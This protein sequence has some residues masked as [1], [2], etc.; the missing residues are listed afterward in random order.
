VRDAAP[1]SL[2]SAAASFSWLLLSLLLTC[3]TLL[4]LEI[5]AR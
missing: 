3:W 5:G 4:Q 2:P 1:P